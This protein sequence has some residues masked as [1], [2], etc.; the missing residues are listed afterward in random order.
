VGGGLLGKEGTNEKKIRK[1]KEK[2][3]GGISIKKENPRGN[4][5]AETC[6]AVYNGPVFS[7]RKFR[8][9]YCKLN[10]N[11]FETKYGLGL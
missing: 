5:G 7:L 2:K 11:I 3:K 9:Y 6:H 10:K 4:A 8:K 1:S